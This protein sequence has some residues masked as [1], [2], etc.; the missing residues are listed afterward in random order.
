M[1]ARTATCS[2][3]LPS[4]FPELSFVNPHGSPEG[5]ASTPPT[6]Y[7]GGLGG[8]GSFQALCRDEV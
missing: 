7:R 3:P 4:A 1:W 2:M 6:L 8:K 5:W